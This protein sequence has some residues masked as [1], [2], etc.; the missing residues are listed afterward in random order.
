MPGKNQLSVVC[1][2]QTIS[3]IKM[4]VQ[5]EQ[6]ESDKIKWRV[7]EEQKVNILK[8]LT[9]F[10]FIANPSIKNIFLVSGVQ[11]VPTAAYFL[12]SPLFY[13]FIII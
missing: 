10:I 7:E 6:N 5:E 3:L 13:E 4:K 1:S 11:W 9:S 8:L 2:L 12:V